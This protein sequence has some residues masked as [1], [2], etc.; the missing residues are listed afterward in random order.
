[1]ISI[2]NE[3]ILLNTKLYK[4]AYNSVENIPFTEKSFLTK[5]LPRLAAQTHR[6]YPYQI[7]IPPSLDEMLRGNFEPAK[8]ITVEKPFDGP[9][10]EMWFGD[11][12]DGIRLLAGYKNGDS[13]HICDYAL[14]DANVHGILVGSTGQGKSVTLN[15]FIYGMCYQYAPWELDLTLCDAKITEF[16]TIAVNNPMPQITAIA[17]TGDADYLISVLASKVEE[18]GKRNALFPIATAYYKQKGEKK[19]IKKIADFRKISGMVMPQIIIIIDEFQTMFKSAGKKAGQLEKIIDS[20]A[21]LGRSTGVHF[22]MASQEVGSDLPPTLMSNIKL[23]MAMGCYSSVSD[24]VLGNSGA[25]ANMGKKGYMLLNDNIEKGGGEADNILF[26][27]PFATD[28]Q[29]A[30]IAGRIM[31]LG[32]KEGVTPVLSFYDE[33]ARV[34]ES[35]YSNFLK[36]FDTSPDKIYLGEPSSMTKDSEQ[37]VKIVFTKKSMETIGVVANNDTNL[38]RYIKMFQ[39]NQEAVGVD[40]NIILCAHPVIEDEINVSSMAAEGWYFDKAQYEDNEFFQE[41]PNFIYRRMLIVLAD[42]ELMNQ[43]RAR[44]EETDK[45][46]E[47]AFPAGSLENTITNKERF[48][49]LISCAEQDRQIQMGLH[50][51]ELDNENWSSEVI[52]QVQEC[53]YMCTS[54]GFADRLLTGLKM[55]PLYFWIIGMDSIIGLG[56]SSKSKFTQ[57]LTTMM[58]N[59]STVNVRVLTFTTSY[60]DLNNVAQATRF[61]II[62]SVATREISKIKCECYPDTINNGLGVLYDSQDKANGCVK[63]KKMIL[64]GEIVS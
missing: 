5:A 35:Q 64:D 59:A 60:E 27:I 45:M 56:R 62:D 39:K 15:A 6:T 37:C 54:Y 55:P 61:F 18:M 50:L 36:K 10:G 43:H 53:I 58:Q 14:G 51:D 25:A 12:S 40:A 8:V 41:M 52:A 34:Y 42:K 44:S 30:T 63:F 28:D 57:E 48:A 31:E 4:E 22:L 38:I 24:K 23:R 19:E 16:K 46:F 11:S 20:F 2:T 9:Y 49:N 21:R 3:D 33:E 26:R 7:K 32:E 13:R 1:M 29:V 47:E 17:A